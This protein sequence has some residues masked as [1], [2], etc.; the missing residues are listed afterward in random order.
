MI[1]I[2]H[3]RGG[4]AGTV[5]TLTGDLITLGRHKDSDVTFDP[6]KD[7]IVSTRHA[8]IRHVEQGYVLV[9][10]SS[11]NG[12]FIGKERIDRKI[13][14]DGDI[15]EIGKNGPVF[16]V[17]IPGEENR[18]ITSGISKDSL[19]DLSKDKKREKAG[20]GSHT[21]AM[22]INA[23]LSQAKGASGG[24]KTTAFIRAIAGEVARHSSKKLKMI[25]AMVSVIALIALLGLGYFIWQE[26]QYGDMEDI[27]REIETQK[28]E[29]RRQ[30]NLLEN[31]K[32]QI[33][34]TRKGVPGLGEN[35]VEQNRNSIYMLVARFPSSR[36]EGFCSGFA[37]ESGIIMTN[38]HCIQQIESLGKKGARFLAMPNEGGRKS[39]PIEKTVSHPG[40]DK[41]SKFPSTD[42]GLLLIKGELPSTVDLATDDELKELKPGQAVYTYGFPG[43]LMEV[44]SPVATIT[45][46]VIGRITTF[47]GRQGGFK[48]SL[49]IQH[50]AF[51]TKGTSGSPVF[52]K[53]GRVIAVNSGYYRGISKVEMKDP[54]TG[55][56]DEV[57]ISRDLSGYAFSVRIDPGISLMKQILKKRK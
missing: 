11:R 47:K 9:D 5:I 23:A 40:Y 10:L 19:K 36:E 13:L 56:S 46:G 35:I 8:E 17:E 37:V 26:I 1:R 57:E 38:A 28:E 49:L 15:V 25:L 20:V 45:Q 31:Q 34:E 2:H 54:E 39:F 44:R 6:E 18:V 29:M 4:R 42:I 27:H 7:K 24:S 21:V 16:R 51:T 55:K 3:V 41:D 43:D 50:S 32:T 30:K 33:E 52:G 22:M 12:T 53:E 14:K 48:N